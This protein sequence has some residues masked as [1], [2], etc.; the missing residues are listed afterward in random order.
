MLIPVDLN[1]ICNLQYYL[2]VVQTLQDYTGKPPTKLSEL[3][4]SVLSAD[5]FK[6]DEDGG[7]SEALSKAL[8]ISVSGGADEKLEPAKE[9]AKPSEE[10]SEP[11]C[12]KKNGDGGNGESRKKPPTS[13]PPPPPPQSEKKQPEVKKDL[14]LEDTMKLDIEEKEKKIKAQK[15]LEAQKAQGA[16]KVREKFH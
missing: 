2:S 7:L 13:Q 8:N 15:A 4:P 6:P 10:S 14:T 5:G 16:Q 9:A 11:K 12:D 1:N 3:F